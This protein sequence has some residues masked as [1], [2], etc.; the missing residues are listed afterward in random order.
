MANCRAS[1]VAEFPEIDTYGS[2]EHVKM[3]FIEPL[4]PVSPMESRDE[5]SQ[6]V[7]VTSH[8]NESLRSH[9]SPL[10]W[11]SESPLSNAIFLFA[12]TPAATSPWPV[13]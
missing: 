3:V 6:G 2:E 4:T 1:I 13:L 10:Q 5:C 11:G 8:H 12:V 7:S 9:A